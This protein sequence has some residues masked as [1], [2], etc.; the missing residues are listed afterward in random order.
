MSGIHRSQG[1]APGGEHMSSRRARWFGLAAAA[2]SAVIVTAACSGSPAAPAGTGAGGSTEARNS[3]VN[4]V[5][6][7]GQGIEADGLGGYDLKNELCGVENGAEVDGPY[8]LWVFTA[9]GASSAT[10]TGPWGTAPMTQTA[11][12]T[13]KYISGFYDLGSLI[14]SISAP[15]PAPAGTRS[16]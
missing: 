11:N 13:Y 2:T 4:P 6:Y 12:G 7:S 15:T 9:T 8:L 5:V 3:G 1:L 14:G 16:S 10:I